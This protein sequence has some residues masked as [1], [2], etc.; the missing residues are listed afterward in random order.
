MYVL[1]WVKFSIKN[2]KHK[3][4]HGG[5]K[6]LEKLGNF[7]SLEKWEPWI[8]C[9]FH[10]KGFQLKLNFASLKTFLHSFEILKTIKGIVTISLL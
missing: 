6:I 4:I 5:K 10:L 3:N 1:K 9:L 7:V 2:T 8:H